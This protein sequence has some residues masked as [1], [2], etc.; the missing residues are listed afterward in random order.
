MQKDWKIM[1]KNLENYLKVYNLMS[2]EDCEKTIKKVEEN[3][4]QQHFFYNSL[5]L[6][7]AAISG[8]QELEMSYSQGDEEDVIMKYIWDAFFQ[9]TSELNFTWF[10]GWTAYSMVRFNRYKETTKMAEHCD[11]IHSLFDGE[12]KGIP[13]LSCLG[14]LNDNYEGGEL[15]FWENK[16]IHVKQGDILVWPSNFLYPHRVEPVTTGTRYSFVSWAW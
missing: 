15:V 1:E 13:V 3:F 2:K 10:R 9:Y 14:I 5:T 6:E 8:N 4:W 12:K 16:K 11:H 7:K